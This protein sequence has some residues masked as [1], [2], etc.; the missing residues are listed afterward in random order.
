MIEAII[1]YSF[2]K[3]TGT[4]EASFGDLALGYKQKLFHSLK[5]GTI[6]SVGGELIAPTG[7][8]SLG[9]GGESTIFETF[10][11][12]GQ[13]FPADSFLQVHT[14]IELPAHTDKVAR[15]YY[16][17]MAVGKTFATNGGLGR[18]WSPMVEFIA[19][20]ELVSGAVTN[21]DIVPEMQ[22]PISKRLHL[23]GSLGVKLPANHT[24]DRPRQLLFYVLWDWVD[25]GLLQGW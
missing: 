25:G 24:E 12:W 17:R 16:L 21:W 20:R 4:W 13:M 5:K 14:G 3:D 22:I 2:T 23:L 1:P 6:V 11:A 15:A 9:T 19:D 18:R 7:N 10:G 8:T